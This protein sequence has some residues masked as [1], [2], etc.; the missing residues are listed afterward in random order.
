MTA[1]RSLLLGAALAAVL[2]GQALAH[3]DLAHSDPGEGAVLPASPPVVEL[4]LT[5]PMRVTSLRLRNEAGKEMPLRREGATTG[6]VQQVRAVVPE[7]LASGAY[8]VEW[9]GASA[10]GHV[11]GGTLRFR[12]GPAAR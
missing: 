10:D 4:M 3:A 5:E 8:R 11:G 7:P 9:R 2:G 6:I 12:V 1:H